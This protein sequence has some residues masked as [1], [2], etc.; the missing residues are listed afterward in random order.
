M[1]RASDPLRCS[2]ETLNTPDS[3]LIQKHSIDVRRLAL[4]PS[5][6]PPVS[7][8]QS[9]VQGEAAGSADRASQPN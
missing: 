8:L 7:M 4:I 9:A 1:F 6:K 2:P 5:Q 3:E